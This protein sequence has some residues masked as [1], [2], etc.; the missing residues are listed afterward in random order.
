MNKLYQSPEIEI[1][2]FVI[3]CD[4]DAISKISGG[5]NDTNND[6]ILGGSSTDEPSATSLEVF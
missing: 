5:S 3:C 2:K 6:L 4:G 1:E